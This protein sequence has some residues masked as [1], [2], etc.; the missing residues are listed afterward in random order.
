MRVLFDREIYEQFT[1]PY[2]AQAQSL[3]WIATANIKGTYVRY[4]GRFITF[5][6]LISVLVN[7]GVSVRIIHSELPSGPFRE[8]YEQLDTKGILSAGV[9]FLHCIR[10]HSK[11][12]IVDSERALVGSPNLTGAGIGAKAGARRNFEIAVLFEGERETQPFI[13]YFD[14]VWMGAP[15]PACGRRDICP[16][17]PA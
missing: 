1:E 16:A 2:L 13:D 11:L 14:S 7:R 3:V 5:V 12:Y 6:D 8:R 4:R 15:C 17:P 10:M 9:E